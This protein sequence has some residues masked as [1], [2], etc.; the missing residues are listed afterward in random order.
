MVPMVPI[1]DAVRA[2]P[3]LLS[4][5]GGKTVHVHLVLGLGTESGAGL[6]CL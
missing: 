4:L 3:G 5:P 1:S 2:R 6:A